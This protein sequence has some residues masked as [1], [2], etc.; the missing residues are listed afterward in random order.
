MC[1][2]GILRASLGAYLINHPLVSIQDHP[3][4]ATR[5]PRTNV[6]VNFQKVSLDLVRQDPKLGF[7]GEP[8]RVIHTGP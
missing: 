8:L 1:L 3:L 2:W 7:G 5:A 4:G 6:N